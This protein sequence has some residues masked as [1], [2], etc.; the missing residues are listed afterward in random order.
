[1][2]RD[3][4]TLTAYTHRSAS[5]D[6]KT[7]KIVFIM[8]GAGRN[9][10]SYLDAWRKYVEQAGAFAIAPEFPTSLYPDSEDY[11]L[12]VGTAGTPSG[13]TYDPSEWRNPNDTTHSEIEHLFEAVRKALG[14]ATCRY[15]IYGHS[16]GGQFVHRLVTFRPDARFSRAVAANSGWYTLPSTGG[17]RD[18]NFY[19]PYGL[20]GAPPDATRLEKMFGR[21]LVVLL[22]E[23]DVVRDDDFRTTRQADAQGL[24]RFERGNFYF[25][26]AKKEASA[27]GVAFRWTLDTVP[28]V[29]HSNS[30]MAGAA[31]KYLFAP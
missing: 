4:N 31:A 12:G 11:N 8:H 14:N 5:F 2:A 18:S 16:A 20:Q 26:M 6:A 29:A 9:A 1:M 10:S 28:G 15:A 22:G 24:N 13:S 23:D 21:D 19:M 7:G 25:S 30:G 3:G 17:G 27:A